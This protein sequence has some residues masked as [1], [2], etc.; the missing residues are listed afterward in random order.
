MPLIS[1][2]LLILVLVTVRVGQLQRDQARVMF[3]GLK[4]EDGTLGA[5]LVAPNVKVDQGIILHQSFSQVPYPVV[6]D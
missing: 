3:E 2:H 5:H 6:A 1:E 4:Q